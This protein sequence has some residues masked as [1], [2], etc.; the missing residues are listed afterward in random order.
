[1]EKKTKNLEVG[2]VVFIYYPSSIKDHYRLARVVETKP[3]EKGLVRSVKVCYRKKNKR[4]GL[5]E[6]RAKPLTQEWVAV[7][8]L[9]VLIPASEQSSSVAVADQPVHAVHPG[10]G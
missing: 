5:K 3:D 4:E 9:S 8:R 6:Y 2:D 7:Q 10:T 1:M